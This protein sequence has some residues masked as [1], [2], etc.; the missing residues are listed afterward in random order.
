MNE[1]Q[2]LKSIYSDDELP[3]YWPV[4]VLGPSGVGKS[5]LINHL[6]SKHPDKFGFSVS[7]TTR[8][9]RDGEVNGKDYNFVNMAEFNQMEANLDFVESC[10]VHGNKYGTAKSQID[11]LMENK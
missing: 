8:G 5:T 9:P 6:K 10:E 7:Y 4:V 2:R 3:P 1:A 11:G